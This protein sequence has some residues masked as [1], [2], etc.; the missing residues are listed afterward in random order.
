MRSSVVSSPLLCFPQPEVLAKKP[1]PSTSTWQILSALNNNSI[2]LPLCAAW[3]VICLLSFYIM[4]SCASGGVA[5]LEVIRRYK[6]ALRVWPN[7]QLV[8]YLCPHREKYFRCL[9]T[10]QSTSTPSEFL[11][12]CSSSICLFSILN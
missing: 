8:P 5:S 3:G 10:L 6:G 12:L 2:T 1:P 11:E 4:P 7:K 9:D